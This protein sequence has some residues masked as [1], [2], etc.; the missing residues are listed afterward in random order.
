MASMQAAGTRPLRERRA[1]EA[2]SSADVRWGHRLVRWS[3]APSRQLP[4]QVWAAPRLSAPH[5]CRQDAALASAFLYMAGAGLVLLLLSARLAAAPA[6]AAHA[7]SAAHGAPSASGPGPRFR[8]LGAARL[9]HAAAA[10][11][12]GAGPVVGPR[13]PS[14][15]GAP[16]GAGVPRAEAPAT[17]RADD[18]GQGGLKKDRGVRL[19]GHQGRHPGR[20]RRHE[21]QAPASGGSRDGGG[22]S[23]HLPW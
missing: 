7:P 17:L 13:A 15:A 6:S 23:L 19:G 9:P 12:H 2:C 3:A 8:G 20:G 14:A 21:A 16:A 22:D 18:R 10:A 11:A 1:L 5:D 4:V